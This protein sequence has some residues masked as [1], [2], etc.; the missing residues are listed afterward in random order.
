MDPGLSLYRWPDIAHVAGAFG[1]A[2]VTVRD[3][4]DLDHL[5]AAITGR[6]RPLLVHVKLDPD[7]ISRIPRWPADPPRPRARTVAS[8]AA[9]AGAQLGGL[10]P[11]RARRPSRRRLPRGCIDRPFY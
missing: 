9:M 4:D 6:D 5:A 7:F 10:A 2:N 3:L 11:P 8:R 1:C